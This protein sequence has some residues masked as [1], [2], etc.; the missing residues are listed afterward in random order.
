[1]RLSRIIG[2]LNRRKEN[3]MTGA[4][5]IAGTVLG[6]IIGLYIFLSVLILKEVTLNQLE[7]SLKPYERLISMDPVTIYYITLIATPLIVVFIHMIIGVVI[8][9]GVNK[10]KKPSAWKILLGGAAL[11]T[12]FGFITSAPAPRIVTFIV[13]L[14]AWIVFSLVFLLTVRLSNREPEDKTA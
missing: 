14:A 11:G 13:C 10:L 2:F 1:M 5:F 6:I 7:L 8:G 9:I 3:E 12:L 4:G